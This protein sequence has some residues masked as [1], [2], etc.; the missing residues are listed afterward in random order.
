MVE[1]PH[2][3]KKKKKKLSRYGSNLSVY[4]QMNKE[5]VAYIYIYIYM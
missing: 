5:A 3:G 1:L 4:Q 2:F